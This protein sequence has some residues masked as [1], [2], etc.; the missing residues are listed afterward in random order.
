MMRLLGLVL[1]LALRRICRVSPTCVHTSDV[2]R[3]ATLWNWTSHTREQISSLHFEHDLETV[4]SQYT[5]ISL[6]HIANVLQPLYVEQS[7]DR[8]LYRNLIRSID[9]KIHSSVRSFNVWITGGS[10]PHG[11]D[12]LPG[13]GSMT[14]SEYDMARE[15]CA[16]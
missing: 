16:W 12:C 9:Q 4:Y 7:V 5:G 11:V 3:N 6:E 8:T 2:I 15:N 10:V 13:A 1:F 14:D